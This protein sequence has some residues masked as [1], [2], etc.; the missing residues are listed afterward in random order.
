MA[1][2]TP[3]D[4]RAAISGYGASD[5]GSA[6]GLTDE[7]L[8]GPL[9]EA[10]DEIDARLA[11]RYQT[12]FDDM[13]YPDPVPVPALVRRICVGIA[14]YLATLTFLRGALLEPTH[15]VSLRYARAQQML[16]GIANGSINLDLP[17]GPPAEQAAETSDGGASVVN[18][19][20]GTLFDLCDFGIG[21]AGRRGPGFPSPDIY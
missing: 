2:A 6:A 14:A 9:Q 17:A 19:Y 21:V 3:D 10:H 18:Q 15:P 5:Q 8:L 20:T 16:S 7:Q 11:V 12:P 13:R 1:Y 4:V